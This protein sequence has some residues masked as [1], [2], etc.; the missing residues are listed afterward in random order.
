MIVRKLRDTRTHWMPERRGS[1]T[2][3][4]D[5]LQKLKVINGES[6]F[7]VQPKQPVEGSSGRHE[8]G[9][10]RPCRLVS[11]GGLRTEQSLRIRLHY[12]EIVGHVT[13]RC[14]RDLTGSV[15]AAPN[16]QTA[17]CSSV[18]SSL[19]ISPS[20]PLFFLSFFLF[21]TGFQ[22]DPKLSM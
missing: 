11:Q 15:T 20:A 9:V 8:A 22:T 21:E 19:P 14:Q 3:L 17:V 1:K 2:L 6:Y 4:K 10:S 5:H 18:S 16:P 12:W 13:R 7:R